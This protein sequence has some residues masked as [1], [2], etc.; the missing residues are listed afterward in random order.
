MSLTR[1]KMLKK[2]KRYLTLFWFS[3]FNGMAAADA[4]FRGTSEK[5]G[6][7][8]VNQQLKAGGVM[9][10][11]LEQKETREVEELRDK[12]YRV[13]K[14]SNKVDTSTVSMTFDEKGEPVFNGTDKRL[15]KKTKA[16]FIRRIKVFGEDELPVR[17]IQDN[18]QIEKESMI[19]NVAIPTGLYDYDVTLTVKRDAFIPRFELEKYVTKIVVRQK[20]GA[21]RAKVDLYTPLLASQFGKIDA[22]FIANLH[23]IKDSG[24]FRSDILDIKW[25]E[26]VSYKAWNADDLC[27]FSYSDVK[28]ESINIFDGNFVITFDCKIETDGKYIPEKY[29]TKALDEKYEQEAP[30]HDGIDISTI[31]RR[32]KRHKKEENDNK[33]ENTTLKL[34]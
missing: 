17:T 29:K 23:Q 19:N 27:L 3:L 33:W 9:N 12:H 21:E 22:I 26:W 5:D 11:L 20:E 16:D 1:K 31:L 4:V 10:D 8:E 6:G 13:Y 30:K 7:V 25:L 24:D 18:K 32:E 2:I 14:E 34:E 28:P 15:K